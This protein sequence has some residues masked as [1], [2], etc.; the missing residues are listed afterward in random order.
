MNKNDICEAFCGQIAVH[1]VPAGLAVSGPFAGQDGDPLGFYIVRSKSGD[2]YRLEDSGMLL[3]MIEASGANLESG[4]RAKELH[5]LL[6]EYG[7]AY[8]PDSMEIYSDFMQEDAVPSAAVQFLAL[9]LRVQDLQ[10]LRS[11]VVESTF[12]EDAKQAIEEM[13]GQFADIEYDA[14]PS[15]DLVD[16]TADVLLRAKN[17]GATAAVYFGTSESRISEAITAWLEGRWKKSGVKI[18]MICETE[19]PPVNQKLWRRAQNRLDSVSFFRGDEAASIEK[20]GR[21]IGIDDVVHS[22]AVH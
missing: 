2:G 16:Y 18:A 10:M 14:A 8:D 20:I 13:L 12:K 3:P 4:T 1:E 9:L 7:A 19:K 5:A 21:Q 15:D 22:N 11:E 6:A 17:G